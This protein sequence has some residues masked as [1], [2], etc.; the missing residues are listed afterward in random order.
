MKFK[1]LSSKVSNNFRLTFQ[2]LTETDY[3]IVI[4]E[5]DKQ[6]SEM[7]GNILCIIPIRI[8]SNIKK[9]DII[10]WPTRIEKKKIQQMNTIKVM[11]LKYSE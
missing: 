4:L 9:L 8:L 10:K 11:V 5:F 7:M 3:G 6:L 2:N 1:C